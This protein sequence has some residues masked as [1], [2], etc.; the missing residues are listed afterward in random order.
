VLC[1]GD[2]LTRGR[3]DPENYPSELG[4]IL[5]RRTGKPYRVLN[6]GVPGLTTTQLRTRF[7]RYLESYHPVAVLH[8]A[9]IDNAWCYPG[10]LTL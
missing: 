3:P 8:W 9:G 10:Q 2:S 7:V 6:L 4:R 1:V 5:T